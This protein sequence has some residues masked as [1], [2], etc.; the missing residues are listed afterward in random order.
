MLIYEIS[1]LFPLEYD[2]KDIDGKVWCDNAAYRSLYQFPP[3]VVPLP[4]PN[5]TFWFATAEW[6]KTI[7]LLGDLKRF[8]STC[9]E[10]L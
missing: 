7:H 2:C 3:Y 1:C 9:F 10:L 5:F 4:L 6:K 8:E